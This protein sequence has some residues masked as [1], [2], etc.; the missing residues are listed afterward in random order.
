MFDDLLQNIY[1]LILV[2][3]FIKKKVGDFCELS[4]KN[5]DNSLIKHEKDT[6][7]TSVF[8]FDKNLHKNRVV[9]TKVDASG[10]L[11]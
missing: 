8:I 2:D 10:F 6:L 9:K 1:W 7:F 3:N 5:C 11:S 4:K